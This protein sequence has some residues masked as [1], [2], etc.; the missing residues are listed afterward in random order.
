MAAIAFPQESG[1]APVSVLG[2]TP[3]ATVPRMVPNVD[4]RR[5]GGPTTVR[6][7]VTTAT[8][9]AFANW[10]GLPSRSVG[11]ELWPSLLRYAIGHTAVPDGLTS[12][13]AYEE[14]TWRR[15][16]RAGLYTGCVEHDVVL[17]AD[18]GRLA[19]RMLVHDEHEEIASGVTVLRTVGGAADRS[20]ATEVRRDPGAPAGTWERVVTEI[21]IDDFCGVHHAPKTRANALNWAGC[22]PRPQSVLPD[23]FVASTL[24]NRI[25]SPEQGT[26]RVWTSTPPLV[27]AALEWTHGT[28]G[29]SDVFTVRTRGCGTPSVVARIE[30]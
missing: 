4:G 22:G 20:P 13:A 7:D 6:L 29:P 18:D 28:D 3:D 23:A 27:G 2:R 16:A 26:A 30:R 25:G 9:R 5:V 10:S 15:P 19:V 8:V 14:I 11:S 21:E 1:P 17:D 24:L 12:F